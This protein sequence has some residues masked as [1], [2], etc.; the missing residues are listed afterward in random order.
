MAK[1]YICA[2]FEV[3]DAVEWQ[4]YVPLA[5]ASLANFGARYVVRGGDPEALE[6]NATGRRLSIIEFESRERASEWYHS[7]QYQAAKAVRQLA[8]T[9]TVTLLSGGE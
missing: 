3:I 9:V 7:P 6:G 2:E 5:Q 4:R 1:G 8:A